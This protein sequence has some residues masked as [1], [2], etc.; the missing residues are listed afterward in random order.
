M[1]SPFQKYLIRLLLLLVSIMAVLVISEPVFRRL[2]PDLCWHCYAEPSLGWAS[3]EYLKVD[4]A[5]DQIGSTRR[6]L[7]LGDSYLA[8]AGLAGLEERFPILVA[9]EL[10]DVQVRVM[11]AGGW[12]TDQ[13]LLAFL[14]KG[15][16]WHPDLV[17][18]TFCANNDLSNNLSNS[19]GTQKMMKPYFQ[20]GPAGSLQIHDHA[21]QP[22]SLA[23]LTVPSAGV[24]FHSFLYDFLVFRFSRRQ[25][26][27][28]PIFSEVDPRYQK[29]LRQRERS[30]ELYDLPGELAWS[31][32]DGVNHV[33]A[34]IHESFPLNS[35]QW[36]LLRGLLQMLT[37]EVK[38]AGGQLVVM[39]LPVTLKPADPRFIVGG[40]LEHVFQTPSG[41]FTFRAAEPNERLAE[42][43]EE[44]DIPY[45]DP[46]PRFT[47]LV[48]EQ[49][50]LAACWPN[51][52]DRHFSAL[53][54]RLLSELTT[55]YIRAEY[56]LL[57][58]N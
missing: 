48:R 46:S 44:L 3:G 15:R 4:P 51:P 31:P 32:Q 14:Q 22:I 8:G 37:T 28:P 21:G 52:T 29:F 49:D 43:C 20:L 10:P 57:A 26:E 5:A 54:H 35:Y 55:A 50:L 13:Q 12:G 24:P 34:Y 6:L 33:S 9:G 1:K 2:K 7:F 17:F 56:S 45:F 39:M 38:A 23:T 19:H 47:R 30:S 27:P 25:S 58:R 16:S 18:L 36:R 42:I 41:P 40:D 11:A 53:G